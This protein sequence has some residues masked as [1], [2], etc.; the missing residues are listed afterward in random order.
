MTTHTGR[1]ASLALAALAGLVSGAVFL[2]AAE[3][4]ALL[5]ARTASPI[6]AVGGFVIDIVPQPFKEF[7]I[8]TFGANDKIALLAG[9]GLAVV[10]ASAIGGILEY[11]RS[12]SGVVI[13]A[14]AGVLSTAA[15]VSRTG[16]TPLSF[17]PPV[18]GTVAASVVLILLGRRLRLWRGTLE[19]AD[20]DADADADTASDEAP[21]LG[22][23]GF[24]RLAGVAG[25]S[26]VIVGVTARVV[27]AATSS[28]DAIRDALKLPAPR[29][30]LTV[31]AGAELD[32]PG[33]SPLFTP[34][35]DFYRVDTA[36][37]VPA[38]DPSTW[39]LV[40]DGMVDRRIELSF[41]GLVGMGLDEYGITLTCVSNEVGGGLVGNARWLGVPVRDILRMAGPQAGADMVLSR[42]VDGY[43]ASTP[44]SALTDDGLDAILAVAMN[45]EPLPAEHGFPVRMIVPGL[46]GYVSATKWLTELKVTTF[47]ADEA[48][49]TPRGYSAEAPIKLSSRVDVPKVGSPVAP[50]RVPVAGMAWAQPTG[51]ARVEVNIDDTG[52]IPATISTP[53]NDES[54]VQW[55][56]EWDAAP[57]THYVAVR[58]W[59]KKGELQ[60][61]QRAP[62][63]PNGSTGWHRVLVTVSS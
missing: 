13:V 60:E 39:R 11:L 54:W 35:A 36:L 55:M 40:V 30:T 37:T 32:V 50:G 43:T 7:A 10:I 15:V 38:I 42:S 19:G 41:D 46:Y 51:V 8:A 25:V 22:R 52:W 5:L 23:R 31:P 33:L 1:R 4:L 16:V 63:A 24:F 61:Q 28:V 27:T 29:R 20:A 6:L 56:Y 12:P 21:A 3:L 17:L 47:A 57:G 26:A 34:N 14:I 49:W 48:Y 2:G 44:L 9:L 59:N 53:V 58:A 62:V 45:G 18:V